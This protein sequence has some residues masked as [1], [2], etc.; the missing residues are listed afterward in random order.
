V[1]VLAIVVPVAVFGHCA[2]SGLRAG[3]PL[4]FLDALVGLLQALIEH[5]P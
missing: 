5:H 1:H 2:I 4:A 3:H